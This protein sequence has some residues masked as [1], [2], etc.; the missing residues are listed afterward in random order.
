VIVWIVM[1]FIL[2]SPSS[3][4]EAHGSSPKYGILPMRALASNSFGVESLGG[5]YFDQ[6]VEP[7]TV[8]WGRGRLDTF[9][10]GERGQLFHYWQD[11]GP[12]YNESLGGSWPTGVQ[13]AAVSWGRGR[14][15]V[16][17]IGTNR[18]LYHYWQDNGPFRLESLGGNFDPKEK[19]AAVTW[20]PRRLDVFLITTECPGCFRGLYH[21]WQDNGP[22]RG[23]SLGGNWGSPPKAVTWGPGR[24]D[25]FIADFSGDGKLY[26]LWGN[27]GPFY[28]ESWTNDG[29]RW[30]AESI[31]AVTSG[32]PRL[33]IFLTG[34]YNPTADN[35]LYHLWQNGASTFYQES[36]GG[37]WATY[38]TPT[39]TT[40]GPG[41]LD[42]FIVGVNK[43]LAH[44]WQDNS[45][46]KSESLGPGLS[47]GSWDTHSPIALSAVTWGWPRLDVFIVASNRELYH[48]WQGS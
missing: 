18:Q 37:Q 7:A 32:K 34:S 24:L 15:D 20:G 36:L 8:S 3:S 13:P 2:A 14:L 21:F 28:T 35:Q 39:A 48:Y 6:R 45:P 40:W 16:F 17:L 31:A 46:F 4:A 5:G 19:I 47:S 26:H 10:I 44:Y 27:N 33:D 30:V 38:L 29:R 42:L 9:L 23:E 1:S 41:R 22:F 12:F 11:N 43:E 25:V